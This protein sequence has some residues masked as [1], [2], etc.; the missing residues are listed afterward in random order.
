MPRN[1]AARV[2]LSV[3]I[4]VFEEEKNIT[5]LVH[6]IHAALRQ[7]RISY[8]LVFIDDRSKD[9]SVELL[10]TLSAEYPVRVYVKEGEKGKCQSLSEGFKHTTG[11]YIAMIDGDLQYPPKYIPSMLQLVAD[12]TYDI[13]VGKRKQAYKE[14][15]LRGFISRAYRLIFGQLVWNLR[16]DVQSGLKVF[17]AEILDRIDVNSKQWTFDLEFLVKARNAGYRVGEVDIDFYP[18]K[19]GKTKINLISASYQIGK[20]SLRLRFHT[21][22]YIPFSRAENEESTGFHY[23]GHAYEPHNH[24][25]FT[26]TAARR[27]SMRQAIIGIAAITVAACAFVYNFHA[28]VETIIG[29]LTILY[30]IDLLLSL[31]LIARSYYSFTPEYVAG[32]EFAGRKQW[33]KYT[34]F[35][36]LYKE[37][38]VLPQFI[39]A[40]KHLDYPQDKLE[41][42]LLLEADDIDT[43]QAAEAMGLP[44]NFKVVIVPHSMPKTKPKACNFGL[45]LATGEYVV[46]YDAEDIPD[47]Q[48]LKKAITVFERAT[49]KVGCIQAKLNYYNWDQNLLTRLFTLE[50]SLWFDLILPGLQSINAPIPLG[51]TSN[52]FRASDLRRF[53]GWD[54]FNVTEDADLGIRLAKGGYSTLILDSVT[55]EEANSQYRN[56]IRQRSRWVKGYIQTYFVHT[57][58]TASRQS[59]RNFSI[60]QLII[61]GKVLSALVNPILWSLTVVYF[62]FRETAGAYIHSLYSA[63]VFYIALTTLIVGNFMYLYMYMMGAAKRGQP[64][65][66]LTAFLVPFYWLMISIATVKAIKEFVVK[67]YHWQKTT[68]GLHLKQQVPIGNMLT[69]GESA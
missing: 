67:P 40:M 45:K 27:F 29:A 9:G 25:N 68:H 8:E 46:I 60:F 36:P 24:L 59:I 42:M 7:N 47:P 23:K 14:S 22:N 16:I 10:K 55:M 35:C 69:Q 65:L 41:I 12:G 38:A 11:R 2:A 30:F 50:Y 19:D 66:I 21:P 31:L 34:I 13:V 52:H 17:R 44:G 20:E 28:T 6:Q 43:I 5:P 15:R 4:P 54:P 56:W 62:A 64:E 37:T 39:D 18:R 51:G 57:R 61:G 32:P 3:V 33:P 1:R 63:P 49:G 26:E 58:K 53:G 48:Q